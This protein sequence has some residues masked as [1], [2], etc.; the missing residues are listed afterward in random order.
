M[1][2]GEEEVVEEVVAAEQMVAVLGVAEFV[3][4]DSQHY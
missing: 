4:L 3:V 1:I 2:E